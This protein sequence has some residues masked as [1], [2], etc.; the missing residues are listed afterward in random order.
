[1][2]KTPDILWQQFQQK[3]SLSNHQI[4][5]FKQ[6]Y[7]LMITYN[8]D[9]NLTTITKL[10]NVIDY[11]FT[12]SLVLNK[13]ID[14]TSITGL[15]DIG[16]GAGFPGIPLKILYPELPVIL[17]EV[18]LKKINFLELVIETLNLTGIE[19]YPH[20]WRTFLRTTN[21]ANSNLFCARASLVVPELFRLFKPGCRYKNSTL[22]YWANHDY[23]PEDEL[24][25]APAGTTIKQINPYKVGQRE[26]KLVTY[27]LQ[28]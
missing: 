15:V 7:D 25:T 19:V 9:H 12:D 10:N 26:R 16:S 23:K 1:M 3:H 6:Y 21:Y 5:Q 28:L 2:E 20:D 27:T 24:N 18:T 8:E 13:T 11:H 14:V 22:T 4:E 17:I